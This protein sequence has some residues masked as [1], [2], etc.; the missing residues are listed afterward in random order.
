MGGNEI[1][2]LS[3]SQISGHILSHLLNN[4]ENHLNNNDEWNNNVFFFKNKNPKISNKSFFSPRS[5][6]MDAKQA[7]GWLRKSEYTENIFN[8]DNFDKKN[9]FGELSIAEKPEYQ[10]NL[11]KGIANGKKVLN[12]KNT[13]YWTD[14]NKL[15]FDEHSLHVLKNWKCILDKDNKFKVVQKNFCELEFNDYKC[16]IEEFKSSKNEIESN[17]DD[18]RY[19]FENC[20]SLQ[21]LNI[22]TELDSGWSGYS[23]MFLEE[24]ENEF[25]SCDL[26]SNKN[27]IWTMGVSSHN[28]HFNTS[29]LQQSQITKIMSIIGLYNHSNLF[30]PINFNKEFNHSI[31]D[32]QHLDCTNLWHYSSIPALFINSLWNLNCQINEFKKM[33][34]ITESLVK[35]SRKRKIVNEIKI[36]TIRHDN[37]FGSN[38]ESEKNILNFNQQQKT[39]DFENS[40]IDISYFRKKDPSDV[41]YFSKNYILSKKN[42]QYLSNKNINSSSENVYLSN[43]L[44]EFIDIDS[45]PS[46]IFINNEKIDFYTE[47]NTNSNLSL[48]LNNY[49]KLL[50][51]IKNNNKYFESEDEKLELVEDINNII[52]EYYF[53]LGESDFFE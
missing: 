39:H 44:K 47:F 46:N 37:F 42:K 32:Q 27:N 10:K 8:V 15:I 13:H 18:L 53:D 21:G 52:D 20:D 2:T 6:V 22:L 4:H 23:T 11:D 25:F 40:S 30:F 3:I 36:N 33:S 43:Q 14:F 16:G 45:F 49:K 34:E 5:F 24:I 26:Q 35:D 28:T 50:F 51:N 9:I 1:I 7:Y 17:I 38:E 48:E 29:S 12:V 19:L 31:L 41:H